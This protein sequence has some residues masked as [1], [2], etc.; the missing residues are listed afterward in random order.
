M[1]VLVTSNRIR[2]PALPPKIAATVDV[3]SGGRLDLGLGVG[4]RSSH[5]LARREYAAHG[6]AFGETTDAVESLDEACHVI[7]RL[8]TETE[9]FEV[10]GRHST[11]IGAQCNS[12][13]S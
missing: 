9:P 8:W 4:S 11:L 7:R 1:G 12:S 3:I 13:R 10:F 2:P 6:P 5:P